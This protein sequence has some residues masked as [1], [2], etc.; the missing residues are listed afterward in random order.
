MT[1]DQERWAEA[2]QILKSKGLGA[3][4][5]VDERIATLGAAGDAAGVNRFVAIRTKL[6]ALIH[7]AHA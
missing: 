2:G 1:P 7:A 4:A 6:E 5:F 3:S